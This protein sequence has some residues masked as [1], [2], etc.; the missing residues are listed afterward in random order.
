MLLIVACESHLT[1]NN[2]LLLASYLFNLEFAL[3]GAHIKMYDKTY[4]QLL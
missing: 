3:Q 1:N 2:N 4:I